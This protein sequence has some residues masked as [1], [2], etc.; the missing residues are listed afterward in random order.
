MCISYICAFVSC[1]INCRYEKYLKYIERLYN[2]RECWALS[3]RGSL[4]TRGNNTNNFAE[5]AMR[6]L[7]DKILQRTKAFNPPQLF[8]ILTSRLESYYETRIVGVALGRWES[9]QRSRFLPQDGNIA[10][11]QIQQVMD[12]NKCLFFFPGTDTFI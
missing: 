2:R 4:L 1:L 9:F 3:Y 12:L 11:S 10:A 6:V 8:D 7:E 5:A